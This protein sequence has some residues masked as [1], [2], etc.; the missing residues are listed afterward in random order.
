MRGAAV[1]PPHA[2]SSRGRK[3]FRIVAVNDGIDNAGL[4]ELYERGVNG[5]WMVEP[6]E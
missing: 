2:F 1:T 4:D 5:V 6:T 3:L